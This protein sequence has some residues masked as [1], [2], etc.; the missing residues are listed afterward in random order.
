[1]KTAVIYSSK[2]GNTKKVAE[3]IAQAMP[4]DCKLYAVNEVPADATFDLVAMGFWVDKGTA[5]K[6]ALAFM[7]TLENTRVFSFFTLGAYPDS[8]HADDSLDAANKLYG[9]GCEVIG[10]FRCQGAISPKLTEWMEKLP[11]D[12]PHA[13]DE[14]RRR[15]W[16]EAAQH[17]DA[18]DC[19]QAQAA[20]TNALTT[21]EVKG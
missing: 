8:S 2:T 5:N 13:P 15:R 16:A 19:K 14:A 20:L 21:L 3:A 11:A 17:P 12:H 6:E 18:E 9:A 7:Q 4:H 1:M 10:S